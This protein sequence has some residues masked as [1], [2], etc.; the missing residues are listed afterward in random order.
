MA[1]FSLPPG[2]IVIR[3][4]PFDYHSHFGGIL[5]TQGPGEYSLSRALTHGVDLPVGQ[6]FRLFERA[7]DFMIDPKNPFD[8]LLGR[9]NKAQYERGECAAETIYFASLLLARQL[10]LYDYIHAP[11]SEKNLY[12]AVKDRLRDGAENEWK[13]RSYLYDFVRYFNSKIYSSNKFTPFDDA[14]KTRSFL[15]DGMSDAIK[16]VWVKSTLAYLKA[17]GVRYTQTPLGAADVAAVE[18]DIATFNSD[19]GT[20]Y[21]LLIHTPAAYTEDGSFQKSL[22]N[23][24]SKFIEGKTS[25][26]VVGIDLLGVENRVGDYKAL[27]DVL[28]KN[29]GDLNQK[30]GEGKIA[31]KMMIHIHCGEGAGSSPDNRS[32][33]GYYIANARRLP[34]AAFYRALSDYVAKCLEITTNKRV[35][36]RRGPSGA[37]GRKANGIAGLFDELFR[38]DSFIYDGTLLRR[39]D[40]TSDTTRSLVAYNAK[41]N[42][43]ALCEDFA[44]KSSNSDDGG[45]TWYEVLTGKGSPYAFRL[46][47]DYYYRNYVAAKYPAVTFDTNLGSN[48]ITGASALFASLEG[49]RINRGFRHLEGYI[50]T[51]VLAATGRSV[52][53]LESAAL[54]E[55]QIADFLE[56]ASTPSPE[57]TERALLESLLKAGKN[58]HVLM[59]YLLGALE[60]LGVGGGNIRQYYELYTKICLA[61]AGGNA[62]KPSATLSYQV[63][64]KAFA[65]FQ[66]WRAYLLGAD[67]QGVEHTDIDGEF[68]RMVILLAYELLPVGSTTLSAQLIGCLQQLILTVAGTYWKGTMGKDALES[69]PT[70]K[71]ARMDGFKAPSSVVTIRREKIKRVQ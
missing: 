60:P 6:Y 47:H 18:G 1:Y 33:I 57:T 42:I 4:Y 11:I 34:D 32:M 38:N 58:E 69:E 62:Q 59:T 21:R 14:Y 23:I 64:T 3:K 24:L 7:L 50:D 61:L 65:L 54:T 53:F 30:F 27:F 12:V 35:G 20:E 71:L 41:R 70:Y 17:E 52:A 15:A 46:G 31:P 39:F 63:L 49:Y 26:C 2:E 13:R 36:E 55:E 44:E 16:S 10:N 37:P 5:P 8:Q 45:K 29:M 9:A 25:P 22:Q 67:G 19:E 51:D 66:N 56:I 28:R 48:A 40:I 68:L 43:M